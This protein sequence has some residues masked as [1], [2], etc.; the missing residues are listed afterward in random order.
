MIRTRG[1]RPLTCHHEAGHA[2]ARWWLGFHTDDVAVLTVDEVRGG[3]MLPDRRGREHRC[4]GLANGYD[5]HFPHA[6]E[7]VCGSW[8]SADH[9]ASFILSAGRRADMALVELYAG[10]YAEARFL[11]RSAFACFLSGGGGDVDQ[12]REIAAD[13]FDTQ[14]DQQAAHARAETIARAFVRSPKGWAA[15][16]AVAGAL[17]GRG[18]IDGDEVDAL[19]SAAYGAPFAYDRWAEIWPPTA[20][21]IRSGHLPFRERKEA[22]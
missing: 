8:D 15:I 17:L 19:C 9:R 5:I 6:R 20:E 10:G 11:R 12:A 4:E 1:R 18:R 14:A 22:A 13:W 21:Q 2:V 3:A 16:K 7:Q